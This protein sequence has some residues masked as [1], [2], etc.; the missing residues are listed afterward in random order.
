MKVGIGVLIGL[1]ALSFII[2]V[3]M[4]LVLI[5]QLSFVQKLKKSVIKCLGKVEW[6]NQ[7]E[8][9]NIPDLSLLTYS[10]QIALISLDLLHNFEI[11]Y[12]DQSNYNHGELIFVDKLGVNTLGCILEVVSQNTI[13]LIFR[14]TQTKAE[15]KS[16][17]DYQQTDNVHTGFLNLFDTIQL[18]LNTK[19]NVL[20][21]KNIIIVGH[22]LGAAIA[23]LVARYLYSQK[24]NNII[25]YL[26]AS[27]RVGNLKFA[28]EFEPKNLV[29]NIGNT[30]DI[31]T[32]LPLSVM[33]N[34]KN[35]FVPFLY[36][37]VGTMIYFSS[38][39]GSW[40]SNHL[41]PIY[42]YYLQNQK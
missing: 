3:A 25:T 4:F 28:K 32:N 17:M 31:V 36:E 19:L 11:S 14:G 41:L 39:W 33:P 16:D 15:I 10:S 22:S 9:T 34:L 2:N 30:D 12:A 23:T 27:P 6:V 42:K 40:L 13:F 38:N 35:P 24:F 8:I 5:K 37:H 18:E 29:F 1:F 7:T 20:E 21:N 26:F